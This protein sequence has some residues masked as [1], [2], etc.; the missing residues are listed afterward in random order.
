MRI[1]KFLKATNITKRRSIAQDMCDSGVVLINDRIV[2]SAKVVAVG[3]IIKI[4][5]LES[6]ITYRVLQI[7]ILKHTPKKDKNMYLQEIREQN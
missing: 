7:P 4:K 6:T 1:D 5:Y 3:D 2:K